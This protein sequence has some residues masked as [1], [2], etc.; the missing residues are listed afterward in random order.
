MV[1]TIKD[2][3]IKIE[4]RDYT[5]TQKQAMDMWEYMDSNLKIKCC[6]LGYVRYLEVKN[7]NRSFKINDYE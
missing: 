1:F 2:L 3:R 5:L 7:I 4:A 6:D